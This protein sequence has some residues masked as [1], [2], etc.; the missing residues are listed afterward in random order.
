MAS[1]RSALPDT[2]PEFIGGIVADLDDLWEYGQRLDNHFSVLFRMTFPR[3]QEQLRELILQIEHE[4]LDESWAH[5]VRLKKSFPK[6]LKELEL[7]A[8]VDGPR[9]RRSQK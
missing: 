9:V 8:R 7:Q 1:L 2:D 3:D 5:L 6:L 4:Q